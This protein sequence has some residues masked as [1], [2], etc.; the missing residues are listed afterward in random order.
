[1]TNVFFKISSP[2]EDRESGLSLPESKAYNVDLKEIVILKD[3]RSQL[4]DD[5]FEEEHLSIDTL[6]KNGEDV[7]K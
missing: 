1:M 3:I 7:E 2:G 5:G 6:F 4:V